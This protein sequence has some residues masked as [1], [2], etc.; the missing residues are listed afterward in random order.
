MQNF[1]F[2]LNI[3]LPLFLLMSLGYGLKHL[4]MFDPKSLK[5]LNS[6]A[7]KALLPALVFNNIY[8]TDPNGHFDTRVILFAAVSAFVIF[9][10]FTVVTVIFE[11]DNRRR[12]TLIQ[13]IGRSNSIIFSLPIVASIYGAER[14]GITAIVVGTV[15]P[16]FNALSVIVLSVFRNKKISPGKLIVDVFKNPLIIGSLAGILAMRVG[17]SLPVPVEKTIGDLA[18]AATP[19]AILALGGSFNFSAVKDNTKYIVYGVFSK[20]VVIPG[21]LVPVCVRMGFTG[22]ELVTLMVMYAAPAAVSTF[23]MA[24]QMD[25]DDVLAGQL[26]V[27]GSA[28]SVV[29][30][31]LWIFGLRSLGLI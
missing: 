13:G 2:S 8:Q 17:L 12:A 16:I 27:F 15:V 25:A 20:L 21:I 10:V 29:T 9:G 30:I 31:F 11:K 24:Q 23:T 3:I 28:L 19:L 4:G 22:P 1:I 14:A 5:V 18:K 7:F 26:V 6:L